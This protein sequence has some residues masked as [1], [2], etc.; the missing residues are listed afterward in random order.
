MFCVIKLLSHSNIC[1]RERKEMRK[2]EGGKEGMSSCLWLLYNY[3]VLLKALFYVVDKK[4]LVG[5]TVSNVHEFVVYNIF[6]TNVWMV[7][8]VNVVCIV[9]TTLS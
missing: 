6:L 8:R 9:S 5:F 7:S 2:R 1:V 4:E 3:D